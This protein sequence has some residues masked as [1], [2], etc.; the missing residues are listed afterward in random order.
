MVDEL[1]AKSPLVPTNFCIW[2]SLCAILCAWL[3]FFFF[4]S[5]LNVIS[6]NSYFFIF[7]STLDLVISKWKI[8][9]FESWFFIFTF[10]ILF[11]SFA[12]LLIFFD[13]SL[14]TFFKYAH[15]LS[16]ARK[17][18]FDFQTLITMNAFKKVKQCCIEFKHHIKLAQFST[19]K[20]NFI[21][22]WH[23]K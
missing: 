17:H 8:Y 5:S 10:I 1:E 21:K 4:P 3:C 20:G 6:F 13:S 2:P 19:S 22:F 14:E 11:S 15:I 16:H 12:S 23:F 18:I 9:I 7:P